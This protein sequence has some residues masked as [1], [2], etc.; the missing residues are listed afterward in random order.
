MIVC[1]ALNSWRMCHSAKVCLSR[2]MCVGALAILLNYCMFRTCLQ[3]SS[4]ESL[5]EDSAFTL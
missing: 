3:L 4:G 2:D 1:T 5:Q